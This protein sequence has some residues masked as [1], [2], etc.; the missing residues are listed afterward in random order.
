MEQAETQP[1]ESAL[2]TEENLT[3]KQTREL[4]PSE[5]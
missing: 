2:K 5:W 1:N 3:N 4:Q